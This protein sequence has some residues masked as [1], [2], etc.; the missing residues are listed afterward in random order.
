MPTRTSAF[1][2]GTFLRVFVLRERLALQSSGL[3]GDLHDTPWI[4]SDESL[5]G[6]LM[7]MVRSE[8]IA[9]NFC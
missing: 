6:T 9:T 4:E 8:A 2:A 1:R 5:E 3:G 7:P